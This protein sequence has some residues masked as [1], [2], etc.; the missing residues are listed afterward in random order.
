MRTAVLIDSSEITLSR[1]DR[2]AV[3]HALR[4]APQR[5]GV[6]ICCPSSNQAVIRYAMA[7][8][9]GQLVSLQQLDV[10][11]VVCGLGGLGLDGE[12]TAAR[13]ANQLRA[14]LVLEVLDSTRKGNRLEVVRQLHRGEK[15]ILLIPLPVVLVMSESATS[16]SYVSRY[17]QASIAL[18]ESMH[19]SNL[20]K[21]GIRWDTVR[22]RTKTSGLTKKTDG[23]AQERLCAAFG[24]ANISPKVMSSDG[25]EIPVDP[26]ECAVQLVR[27]LAHYGLIDS[28]NTTDC[29]EL[30]ECLP[31]E[32]DNQ[33]E[34]PIIHRVVQNQTGPY[35]PTSQRAT[36]TQLSPD[37]NRRR[38]FP[39]ESAQ[40]QICSR[41]G[42]QP[43]PIEQF[44]KGHIP[45]IDR[46]NLARYLR[47]PRSIH[48]SQP[49]NQRGPFPLTQPDNPQN[50]QSPPDA[51]L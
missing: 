9:L 17:R 14:H 48:Q 3:E 40:D 45:A 28:I 49:R 38:P 42:R 44:T 50:I 47:R 31:L 24:I 25:S 43:R 32:L 29:L 10:D 23:G 13:L 26:E 36:G 46:A 37:S 33:A 19:Q 41:R 2:A 7:A 12:L 15:E 8:G 39:V 11:L 4:I 20:T 51:R 34:V 18:T 27:Y 30:D 35:S 16:R 21:P 1:S 22:P 6:S 5:A